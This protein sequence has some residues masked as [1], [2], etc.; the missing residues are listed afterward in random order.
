[1]CNYLRGTAIYMYKYIK[2]FKGEVNLQ[3]ENGL[4]AENSFIRINK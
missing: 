4:T 2:C 3:G 1:M